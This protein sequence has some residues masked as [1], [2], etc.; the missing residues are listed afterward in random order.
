MGIWARVT[1]DRFSFCV[2][3]RNYFKVVAVLFGTFLPLAAGVVWL[4]FDFPDVIAI[5]KNRTYD[6]LWYVI[7]LI[8]TVVQLY[9]WAPETS[10]SDKVTAKIF[11]RRPEVSLKQRLRFLF[12]L[13]I[14]PMANATIGIPL[15]IYWS[16]FE[17]E[18]L[19]V[20]IVSVDKF[21]GSDK[22]IASV[23]TDYDS[24]LFSE[25]C[26][27]PSQVD[28][29]QPGDKLEVSGYWSDL[30]GL[31]VNDVKVLPRDNTRL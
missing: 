9:W 25:I 3:E 31:F 30:V 19:A 4:A 1:Q 27:H 14:F 29:L 12:E 20:E 17:T 16:C 13:L 28:S 15:I 8:L 2:A 24:S 21:S 5:L 23:S 10:K 18:T 11:G 7:V 6:I 22:C 26:I